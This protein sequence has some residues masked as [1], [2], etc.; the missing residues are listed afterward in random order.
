[1]QRQTWNDN[2]AGKTVTITP[3]GEPAQG[4]QFGQPTSNAGA[5]VIEATP[6][7]GGTSCQH[8]LAAHGNVLIDIRQCR[9]AGPTDV[10]ALINATADKV[11]RQQ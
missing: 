6:V 1:M 4:W 2:C 11:P 9:S 8:G 10:S 7:V 3:T 5:F